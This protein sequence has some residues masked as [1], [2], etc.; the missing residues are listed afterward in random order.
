DLR[1]AYLFG[2]NLFGADL[3]KT[4]LFRTDLRRADLRRADL[5][6]AS[7]GATDLCQA[8]L[9]HADLRGANLSGTDLVGAD[10]NDANLS[11]AKIGGADFSEA[12]ISKVMMM[13]THFERTNLAGSNFK[14]SYFIQITISDCDLSNTIGLDS[15]E[16]GGP[17]TIGIDTIFRSEGKIPI[18]FLK[19]CGIPEDVIKI[20]LK[21][22]KE[23]AFGF[24]SCFIAYSHKDEIF[25]EKLKK[26][27]ESNNVP[28]WFFPED[29][30]WGKYIE[31]NIERGIREYDKLVVI[32]SENSLNSEPVLREID[33]ALQKEQLLKEKYKKEINVLFPV[34]IDDYFYKKWDHHLKP[35][36]S[37]IVLGDFR[38]WKDSTKYKEALNRL[39]EGLKKD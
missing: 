35:L 38:D 28:C 7:L 21:L 33:R 11:E 24:Y 4:N 30:V 5:R 25:A 23:S 29:A 9:H 22:A 13:R 31:E 26:D 20:V 14:D 12:N 18:S 15:V 16:H 6:E 27:L 37:R 17:S 10:L 32:C 2:A 34:I 19:G 3:R 1:M 39:F 36:I 8:D